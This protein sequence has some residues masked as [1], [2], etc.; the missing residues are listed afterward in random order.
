MSLIKLILLFLRNVVLETI[1]K[2][3]NNLKQLSLY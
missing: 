3:A 1:A 2:K